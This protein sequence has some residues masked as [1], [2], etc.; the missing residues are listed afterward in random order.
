MQFYG[1]QRGTISFCRP[2]DSLNVK[3]ISH[4][5][6][7]EGECLTLN[8]GAFSLQNLLCSFSYFMN[9]PI[10]IYQ[11]P[12]PR[13]HLQYC[14]LLSHALKWPDM[15]LLTVPVQVLFFRWLQG[16]PLLCYGFISLSTSQK[17]Q[18]IMWKLIS[19]SL[20]D[21]VSIHNQICLVLHAC[22]MKTLFSHQTRWA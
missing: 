14:S 21:G 16:V 1:T 17:R 4:R 15:T 18:L 20:R 13:S 19:H 8:C 11:S 6:A 9:G 2:T 12:W 22:Q 5:E 10:F 3:A 7:E